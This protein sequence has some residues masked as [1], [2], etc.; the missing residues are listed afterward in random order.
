MSAAVQIDGLSHRFGERLVIGDVTV[1]VEPGSLVALI[2]PTGCGKS[3]MLRI[4]AGLERPTAGHV[5]IGDRDVTDVPGHVAYMPQMDTLLPWRRAL[6]NALLGA[7]I[8][9]HDMTG[10]ETAAK[11]LFA[12]FGLDGFEQ[13]WPHELSGGMRQ[14]VALLRT[15]LGKQPVIALDEPFASLDSLT[16]SELQGWLGDLLSTAGRTTLLVTHD[17]DEALRLADRI[18]V[19]GPR[20]ARVRAVLTPP[21]PRPRDLVAITSAPFATLKREILQLLNGAL[22]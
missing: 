19:M 16:R 21:T 6:D 15:I 18:V 2:G 10:A 22:G 14:R 17:I 3:T 13:A 4:V 11:Q 20:P 12:D 8:I 9:G 1:H 7:Q 5:R